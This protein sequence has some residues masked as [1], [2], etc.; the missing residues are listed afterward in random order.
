MKLARLISLLL[1]ASALSSQ[2][3]AA[4]CVSGAAY[5]ATGAS[6]CTVP[7][8]VT[9]ISVVAS[10]A[11]GG[12]GWS[13]RTGGH[14]G[15]VTVALTV[16]PGQVLNLFVGAG[17]GGTGG[18]FSGGGGGSS[19]NI[20]AGTANQIIAG[21]GGGAGGIFGSNGGNGNGGNGS[22]FCSGS[23]GSAGLGGA[24]GGGFSA[25]NAGGAGNGGA[26]GAGTGAGGAGAGAGVGG[27]AGNS[28]GDQGGGGG[29]G[30]GGG[31]GGCGID[32]GSGGG[33][34]SVGPAGAIYS[35]A[36]NGG[37]S[38][39]SGGNGSILFTS[40][41]VTASAP[42]I[43][44]FSAITPVAGLGTQPIVL[45]LST[46][47]GPTMTS[48]LLNT[49]SALLGSDATYLGQI[50]NGGARISQGGRI[51]SFYPLDATTNVGAGISLGGYSSQYIGTSCGS[52]SVA[53]ALYNL[54]EFGAA[55]GGAGVVANIDAKGVI[56]VMVD[57]T[58]YVAIPDYLVATGTPGSPS[59]VK[60]S[61]GLYRF[62]DSAG[63]VQILRP[64]FLDV[65]NLRVQ[66]QP[67]LNMN[68]WIL[69]QTDGTVLFQNLNNQQFVLTPDLT[70]SIAP[71]SAS[72]SLWWQDGP[73][74]YMFRSS[75]LS[76]AQGFTVRAR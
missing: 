73:N 22:G 50:A 72:T 41:T 3:F 36:T 40:F 13:G 46:G 55:L 68:G 4:D 51:V 39:T 25:G 9:S 49:V 52:F 21:G 30:Y 65:D 19:T 33:G 64:A 61:D 58:Y 29:G 67:A 20:N 45:D 15:V 24:G 17:G 1:G 74:R 54:A 48:C 37:A 66:V 16:T 59:L 43:S 44:S 6:T 63:N 38:A 71:A 12:G 8:G 76:L 34:G 35:L 31:G 75:I 27:A 2:A 56:T 60:G 5:T 57:G 53:P 10:G 23:G 26:G 69:V 28:A 62:T 70:L 42:L 14:G 11:G 32:T 47:S 18:V 7:A